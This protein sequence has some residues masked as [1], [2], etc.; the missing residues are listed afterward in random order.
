MLMRGM[1]RM[2]HCAAWTLL[3]G[4]LAR[5]ATLGRECPREITD[6]R[7]TALSDM[8]THAT[9]IRTKRRKDRGI[10]SRLT[11]RQTACRR[12]NE[13]NGRLRRSCS[14]FLS[15]SRSAIWFLLFDC[16][17]DSSSL[18]LLLF[19]EQ[20]GSNEIWILRYANDWIQDKLYTHFPFSLRHCFSLS[21]V[22]LVISKIR[23]FT[24][25]L[26]HDFS[27]KWW[28]ISRQNCIAENQTFSTSSCVC[29]LFFT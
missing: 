8:R 9:Q 3:D 10:L 11:R 17:F 5:E 21:P 2:S 27:E 22:Y 15:L 6:G 12:Q 28:I 7:P 29:Q 19:R 18:F 14:F 23:N 26:V 1:L 24:C 13:H 16:D 25:K 20:I 4:P